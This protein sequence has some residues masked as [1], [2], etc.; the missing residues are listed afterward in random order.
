MHKPA[1]IEFCESCF[2][3][4][5]FPEVTPAAEGLMQGDGWTCVADAV[6]GTCTLL[7]TDFEYH[8]FRDGVRIVNRVVDAGTYL[9][10]NANIVSRFWPKG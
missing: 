10:L 9:D 1:S 8:Y 6:A 5:V 4:G 7:Q 3:V 2:P